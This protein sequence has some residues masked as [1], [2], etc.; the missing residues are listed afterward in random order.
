MNSKAQ[1]DVAAHQRCSFL[2]SGDPV[3]GTQRAHQALACSLGTR[4]LWVC[5]LFIILLFRA[6][7]A[8]YGGSRARG[9]IRASAAWTMPDLSHVFDLYHSSFWILNPLS[10]ARDPTRILMDPSRVR[11]PLSHNRNSPVCGFKSIST[12]SK[13]GMGWGRKCGWRNTGGIL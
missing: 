7:P 1:P 2:M 5:L 8:A 9:Q 13:A 6:A 12:P 10:N 11:N 3:R 4:C